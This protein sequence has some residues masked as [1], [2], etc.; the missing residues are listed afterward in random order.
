VLILR[1]VAGFA[2]VKTLA[3]RYADAIER[4]DTDTLISMLTRDATWSMPPVPTW[5]LGHAA[6]AEFMRDYVFRVDWRHLTTQANGQL[7]VGCY[8]LDPERG[9][10]VA[11]VLDVLTLRGEKIAAVDGFHLAGFLRRS[12]YDAKLAGFDYF[13]RFGLP[14][15][16]A[17]T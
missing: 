6:I 4:G 5:Y 17:R 10:Y 7:A 12:G 13:A 9:T 8:I 11:S 2:R 16:I 1:E 3:E 14:D 15:E